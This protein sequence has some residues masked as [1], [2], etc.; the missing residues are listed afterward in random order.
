MIG[1]VI[2]KANKGTFPAT[3]SFGRIGGERSARSRLN[4][5]QMKSYLETNGYRRVYKA[6]P[7]DD[8]E[9]L[10]ASDGTASDGNDEAAVERYLFGKNKP[11]LGRYIGS[12]QDEFARLCLVFLLYSIDQPHPHSS[13][14]K[15]VHVF[16]LIDHYT[17]RSENKLTSEEVLALAWYAITTP[18]EELYQLVEGSKKNYTI[19]ELIEMRNKLYPSLA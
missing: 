10:W 16:Q 8:F 5:Y 12:T 2:E 18:R 19:K 6:D 14:D 7:W 15:G 13:K 1:L 9:G 3:Y 17:K 4:Q 11:D